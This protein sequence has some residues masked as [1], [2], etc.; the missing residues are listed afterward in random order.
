[1]QLFLDSILAFSPILTAFLLLVVANRPAVQAM[2]FAYLVTVI[3]A[4]VVWKV[5][6]M[7]I[8]AFTIEEF[9]VTLEI[10]YIMFGAILLLN[11]L[12]ESGAITKIRQ[13]LL[14]VSQDRRIPML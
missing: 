9:I 1:M 8:A 5:P 2:P 7:H 12:Q 3:L 13:S 11:T 14:G 10:L 6:F 4:L